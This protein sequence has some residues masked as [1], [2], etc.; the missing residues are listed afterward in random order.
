MTDATAD[1][2]VL[3]RRHVGAGPLYVAAVVQDPERSEW[4]T[5]VR[6]AVWFNTEADARAAA[7]PFG[8]TVTIVKL[9]RSALAEPPKSDR[10]VIRVRPLSPDGS[11]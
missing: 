4:T 10:P 5:L 9:P 1:G 6:E 7:R 3:Q 2:F 8:P 11:N